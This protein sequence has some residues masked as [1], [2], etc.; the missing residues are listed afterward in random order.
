MVLK[1]LKN[2]KIKLI[3]HDEII[4]QSWILYVFVLWLVQ[5]LIVKEEYLITFS[6]LL[7]F[8]IWRIFKLHDYRG[9]VVLIFLSVIVSYRSVQYLERLK[10]PS[11]EKQVRLKGVIEPDSL[12]WHNQ[13]LAFIVRTY[14]GQR[15]TIYQQQVAKKE[16]HKL[17]QLTFNKIVII[18]GQGR[19]Q[20]S[21]VN[22][23][24]GAFN[25]REYHLLHQIA[26][27]MFLKQH[28]KIITTD[29][30]RPIWYLFLVLRARLIYYNNQYLPKTVAQYINSLLLGYQDLNFQQILQTYQYLGISHLFSLSG[31][32]VSLLVLLVSLFL[33]RLGIKREVVKYLLLPLLLSYYFLTGQNFSTCRSVIQKLSFEFLPQCSGTFI[34]C[35]LIVYELIWHPGLLLTFGP[36]MSCVLSL[37]FLRLP[38]QSAIMT[39]CQL[40]LLT[41]PILLFYTGNVNLLQMLWNLI[42]IPLFSIF[43]LPSLLMIWLLASCHLLPMFILNYYDNLLQMNNHFWSL[44][45]QVPYQIVNLGKLTDL[46]LMIYLFFLYHYF[47]QY[48]LH[49]L[50][51]TNMI[52]WIIIISFSLY[53]QYDI[54]PLGQV[55]FID[56]GQGD[57]IY[58]ELPF[59]QANYLIDTGGKVRFDYQTK[60]QKA[61]FDDAK[62][63][64]WPFLKIQGIRQIDSVIL[65]HPDHDH[66]GN[67]EFLVDKVKI[68]ELIFAK[69]ALKKKEFLKLLAKIKQ[70][71]PQIKFRSVTA[72]EQKI[73]ILQILWPQKVGQGDNSDSIVL[74]SQLGQH[75]FLFTGDIGQQEEQEI[76]HLYPNLDI[77]VLKVAH[78][79]S[80]YSSDDHFLRQITP[81]IAII[82]AGQHNKYHHPHQEVI[83]KLR[84][85]NIQIYE[86]NKLGAITY[87]FSPWHISQFWKVQLKE[88]HK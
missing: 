47:F 85:Q 3:L 39:A 32:H 9:I 52:K 12:T 25:Q 80:K 35:C 69:G 18:D 66:I 63:H 70:K 53:L 76:M 36:L 72:K 31:L 60:K 8:L 26:G 86:T 73:G 17:Q 14:T 45:G 50:Q 57:S 64:V 20:T 44:L 7:I 37:F 78:H 13:K 29:S 54:Q 61:I 27:Q 5:W 55:T 15:Y 79:G 24:L 75:K 83:H 48:N 40:F 81:K 74:Y 4:K 6:C 1:Q 22:R 82:S 88:E 43:I 71:Q 38:K 56:V 34:L 23:N 41:L 2:G 87:Y 67:L 11:I 10:Q 19:L 84:Q 77:D 42:S 30:K 21:T 68:K 33:F 49:K 65:T 62:Y 59:R 58:I 28:P 46:M 51:V 16:Y